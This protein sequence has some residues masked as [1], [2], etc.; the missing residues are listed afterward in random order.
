MN[1]ILIVGISGTGKT[2]IAKRMSK[3]LNLPVVYLDSIFWKESW[4]E[5]N[6]DLVTKKIQAV[7]EEN[8][9]I[10]EGYIEPLG[11]ERVQRANLVLYLDYSGFQAMKGGIQRYLHYRGKTRPEMPAGNTESFGLKF[12]WTLL[13]RQERP[14]IEVAIKG[15]EDK[16][17]RL[18]SRGKTK[19]Y[20]E[21]L[22]HNSK[23]FID[24]PGRKV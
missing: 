17:T 7:I 2:F 22:L 21:Q 24:I 6:E 8:T 5:E 19:Y 12:L 20:L 1:R 4:Q 3:S 13:T 14:E 23:P 18:T 10:I 9:W 15:N 16:V 11:H